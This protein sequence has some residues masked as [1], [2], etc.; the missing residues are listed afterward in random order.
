MVEGPWTG[1]FLS[2]SL[3]GT[4]SGPSLTTQAVKPGISVDSPPELHSP[5]FLPPRVPPH[6]VHL[7]HLVAVDAPLFGNQACNTP[8]NLGVVALW[9]VI[10]W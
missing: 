9:C 7:I 4:I 3:N 1:T 10:S 6:R 5:Y 2:L 8:P